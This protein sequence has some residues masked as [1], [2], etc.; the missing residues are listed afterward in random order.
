MAAAEGTALAPGE[1]VAVGEVVEG[2]VAGL[3]CGAA[4][5]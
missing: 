2:D 1:V 5:S 3:V 4:K